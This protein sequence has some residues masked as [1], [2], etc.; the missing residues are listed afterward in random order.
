MPFLTLISLLMAVSLYGQGTIYVCDEKGEKIFYSQDSTIQIFEFSTD[1]SIEQKNIILAD[2]E[3]NGECT[4]I[5]DNICSIRLFSNNYSPF[6]KKIMKCQHIKYCSCLLENN[7]EKSWMENSVLLKTSD[8][9]NVILKELSLQPLS[10]TLVSP[11]DSLYKVS[12]PKETNILDVSRSLNQ[13]QSVIY[14][15]PL[16]YRLIYMDSYYSN[17]YF[18][19]QWYLRDSTVSNINVLK[20][21]NFTTGRESIL[22]GVIDDGVFFSHPDLQNNIIS[23]VNFTPTGTTFGQCDMSRYEYHGTK[24]AGVIV[25]E[26]NDIGILGIAHTSK[27]VPLKAYYSPTRSLPEENDLSY[28]CITT[29]EFLVDAF[30]SAC[31]SFHVDIISCSWGFSNPIPA[32]KT[33]IDRIT[34]EGR[35]GKG[36]IIC[37]SSGNAYSLPEVNPIN[38]PAVLANVIAVGGSDEETL[39]INRIWQ[40]K[41]GDSLDLVAPGVN[42]MT[43]SPNS[44]LYNQVDGTSFA[45]PQVAATAALILSL[46][47]TLTYQDVFEIICSSTTKPR[48]DE[49]P[50]TYHDDYPYG[51]WNEELGYGLLNVHLALLKTLYRNCRVVCPDTVYICRNQT[52]SLENFPSFP[53][54][55]TYCWSTSP[56][57]DWTLETDSSI[58][59]WGNEA[60]SGWVAFNIIHAGDTMPI[61]RTVVSQSFSVVDTLLGISDSITHA[62]V[63]VKDLYVDSSR[64]LVITDTLLC[65][66]PSRIIVRPGGKLIVDGGTLTSACTG[67]M[68]QGIYVEGHSNLHQTSANQGKVVL[69]NGAVIENALCGIRTGAPGDT[70][71]FATTGGIITAEN[72]TFR[73]CAKAVAYFAYFDTL[74]NGYVN[75]N[76]GSFTNCTFT[77]DGNNLFAANNTAFS[78]HVSLW[79]VKGVKFHG[80]TFNN[81]I[82]NQS[83]RRH[84]IYA[85]SAGFVADVYC[86]GYEPSPSECGCPANLSDSCVFEGF[87]TAIEAATDGMPLAVTVKRARF[88]N[89]GT[90]VRI[91]A[92]NF[93]TVTECDFN[94]QSV[95]AG[96]L[97]NTGLYLD[98]CTGYLVEGNSFLK[99]T[100]SQPINLSSTGIYVKNSGTAKN[101]L[102]RNGFTNLNYG[103]Y[104][105]NNNGD[106]HS[107]LQLTCN[108]FY[109]N[110]YDI[111]LPYKG[112]LKGG[113]GNLFKGADNSFSGTRTSSIYNYGTQ[114]LT[115]YYSR[116]SSHAPYNVSS[117]TVTLNSGATA[118]DC[119]S[120]LC[121]GLIYQPLT[122]LSAFTSLMFSYTPTI[123]SPTAAE[124]PTPTD[125]IAAAEPPANTDDASTIYNTAVR[126]LMADTLLDLAALEQWHA[127]AQP[128]ADPYSLTETRFALGYD[129]VFSPA[130]STIPSPAATEPQ[131]STDGS[132][133]AE[134]PTNTDEFSDY[135]RFHNLKREL[136]DADENAIN[137]YAL[138]SAQI[139]QLQDL[140]ENGTGRSSVMARGVLC[141]FYGICYDEEVM[142]ETRR[143]AAKD[144]EGLLGNPDASMKIYPNPAGNTLHV[145]FEGT[146][147][148]QGTLTVTDLTGVVVLTQ[149]CHNP[150]TQID[151]SN[152]SPGLYVVAFRNEKGVVVKKFVKM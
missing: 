101:T 94:L 113:Q 121:G 143:A 109:G 49:Y 124:P 106:S 88:A 26:N 133:T 18:I 53:D 112:T 150:V 46:D 79:A 6:I 148:L 12:F 48:I 70:T 137:W 33:V 152:L 62:S 132:A 25:A 118:N 145:E 14:S 122:G 8:N 73:N 30:T 52:V 43:T 128:I 40:S 129:E 103:V 135:V 75:D 68:W 69:K 64:T 36:I 86:N 102:H 77:V 119:A 110:N 92:N 125:G 82:T 78:D 4:L 10:V 16:F 51:T 104:V 15:N 131:A 141:F 95:P 34:N 41:F 7:N 96:W 13:C 146:D 116:G 55:I 54:S 56:N 120:T 99:T 47:S 23:G 38:F 45:A 71:A 134:P 20:A 19:N 127:A 11:R 22:V 111:Y 27:I 89:N 107:G 37:A 57:L 2:L 140:A 3:I 31:D 50:F 83:D 80:C 24:C 139:A 136:R 138:T 149:E 108:D 130:A 117:T 115:Y 60:G 126:A 105:K 9:I 28:R 91:S 63:I 84:G 123:P 114:Q 142:A 74:A 5:T 76:K 35:E 93:A 65:S 85:H 97:E 59:V 32:V 66:A 67:E 87:S 72:T 17:P 61:Q 81:L 39:R 144:G 98:N 44:L 90:A 29:D 147:D 151:V 1:I 21:W 58:T 100:Y 42:I